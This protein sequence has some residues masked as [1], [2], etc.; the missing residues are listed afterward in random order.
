MKL[1]CLN[2]QNELKDLQQKL[3]GAYTQDSRLLCGSGPSLHVFV[4]R[5]EGLELSLMIE[6]IDLHV[7]V[8]HEPKAKK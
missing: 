4:S 1:K 5:N 3:R 7:I 6:I 8:S 2:V